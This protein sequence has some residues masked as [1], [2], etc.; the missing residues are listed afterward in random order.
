M[1]RIKID[2]SRCIG[3]LTCVTACVVSHETESTD[4]GADLLP[5]LRA[6]GVC[7]YLYDRSHEK[8]PKDR[9]CGV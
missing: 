5:P 6:A 2:R 4:A 1:Y 7:I 9:L 8:E 3:C